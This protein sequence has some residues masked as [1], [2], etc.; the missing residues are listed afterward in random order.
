MMRTW[1]GMWSAEEALH[2]HQWFGISWLGASRCQGHGDF[3]DAGTASDAAV[4]QVS[5]E[6]RTSFFDLVYDAQAAESYL[7]VYAPV[8]LES[9]LE[10]DE[11]SA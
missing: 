2:A 11:A 10:A 1:G 6:H 3:V 9:R 7:D 8:H 5:P 4:F